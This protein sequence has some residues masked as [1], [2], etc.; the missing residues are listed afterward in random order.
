MKR[1]RPDSVPKRSG[2]GGGYLQRMKAHE[3]EEAERVGGDG[4]ETGGTSSSATFNGRC[5][6]I[7]LLMGEVL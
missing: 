2:G 7:A 6:L 4:A 5:E 1:P 3:L